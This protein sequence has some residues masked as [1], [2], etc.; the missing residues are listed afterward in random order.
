MRQ[1]IYEKYIVNEIGSTLSDWK[2]LLPSS[3]EHVTGHNLKGI[4]FTLKMIGFLK[5]LD[6]SISLPEHLK[7]AT[8]ININ[9]NLGHKDLNEEA[10]YSLPFEKWEH[11]QFFYASQLNASDRKK[12][13][14][15]FFLGQILHAR[16]VLARL[17]YKDKIKVE[18]KDKAIQILIGLE[19]KL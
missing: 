17:I 6:I 4:S 11:H 3:Y 7:K 19:P 18:N 16:V 1:L 15:T 13:T 8:D 14:E 5:D 2:Y 10:S 12:S 9:L